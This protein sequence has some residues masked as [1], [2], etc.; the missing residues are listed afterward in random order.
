MAVVQ[1]LTHFVTLCMAESVR[2]LGVD[3]ESTKTFTSP[4]YQLELSLVGRLLSQDPSL[5][6]DILQQNPY[7]PEVL[8]AC[9]E[10]AETL[11]RIV[12]S[13][14]PAQFRE[15]FEANSRHLGAYC[16]EGMKTTDALIEYHGEPMTIVTLGPEGTFSHELALKLGCTLIRSII[17]NPGHLFCSCQR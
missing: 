5:Y 4:V 15:F 14:D 2:R 6:A 11:T 10:S 17:N 7:V 8:S 3:I 9:T 13:E 16:D 1:G 12:A